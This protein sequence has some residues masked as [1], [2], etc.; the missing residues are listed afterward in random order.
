M[1]FGGS[2]RWQLGVTFGLAAGGCMTGEVAP[3]P[4]EEALGQT[5]EAPCVAESDAAFCA[6]QGMSC[7]ALSGTDDCGAPRVVASCGDCA[8]SEGCAP[9]DD[10]A[11]CARTARECGALAGVDNCGEP[12]SVDSC[13]ECSPPLACGAGGVPGVCGEAAPAAGSSP[14]D[15]GAAGDPPPDTGGAAASKA[16]ALAERLRGKRD[17]LFGVG[18]DDGVSL[19]LGVPL[20]LHYQYLVGQ[21]QTWNTDA[22]GE[23]AFVTRFADEAAAHGMT[24]MF[25]LYQMADR[26]DGAISAMADDSFMSGY[27]RRVR[28]LFQR[29]RAF[30]KPA[31]VQ[32][33]PDFWGY[34]FQKGLR[35]G[36]AAAKLT[37]YVAECA[38]LPDTLAGMGRCF[39]RLRDAL[40][41]K[42]LVGLHV[43]NWGFPMAALLAFYKAVG[44][45]LGDFITVETLDRD[46]GCFEARIEADCQRGGSGWYWDESNATSPNFHDHLA[47]V[48]QI[49]AGL[50]VPV[51]WWQT[52][53]GVPSSSPGSTGRY[54]DNRVRY[55]FSHVAELVAAGGV[56]VVFGSGTSPPTEQTTLTSDGGQF[57]TAAAAYYA[58][59]VALP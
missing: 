32:I 33:E 43:T 22:A 1:Q 6:R 20:D 15:P 13:G 59:P 3:K 51:L 21:W 41:P 14:P 30:D 7:G 56:G 42:A 53:L 18:N 50:G 8:P 38:G 19:T 46:A 48:Q 12:R 55:F 39:V 29:L 35:D 9:E 44:A 49:T 52:P 40:A 24:P 58:S 57:K 16:A 47:L 25:T 10:A 27:W 45:D 37:A 4:A 31:V 54:R 17:F 11:L 26:G 23:G 28:L 5:I 34:A 2:W 36:S